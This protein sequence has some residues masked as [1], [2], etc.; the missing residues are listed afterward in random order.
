MAAASRTSA[1]LGVFA[2]GSDR[3]SCACAPA[4][5]NACSSSGERADASL[6]AAAHR[7]VEQVS[8]SRE[9]RVLHPFDLRGG[10]DVVMPAGT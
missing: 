7:C 6:G 9:K 8:M 1:E 3:A 4:D 2:A 10:L 5:T